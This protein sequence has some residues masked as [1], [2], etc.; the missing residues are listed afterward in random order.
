MVTTYETMGEFYQ[1]GGTQR[2]EV[3]PHD[4]LI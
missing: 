2:R 1:H 4:E 3:N